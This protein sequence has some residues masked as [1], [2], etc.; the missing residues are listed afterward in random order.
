MKCV[1]LKIDP[2]GHD[3]ENGDAQGAQDV[4]DVHWD[5]HV[6]RVVCE[7]VIWNGF[8]ISAIHDESKDIWKMKMK[9]SIFAH[10]N[11]IYDLSVQTFSN[12]LKSASSA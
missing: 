9:N 5:V 8:L 11:M 4:Q 6:N 7:L 1:G 3:S 12:P 2:F 10:A